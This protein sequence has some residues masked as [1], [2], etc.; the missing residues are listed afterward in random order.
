MARTL[1]ASI[2]CRGAG[3]NLT[4]GALAQDR[5][6]GRGIPY[7]KFGRRVR[8]RQAGVARYL[9]THGTGGDGSA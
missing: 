6:Q 8:Y 9:V 4:L 1:P 7:V 2:A 3:L 5:Y